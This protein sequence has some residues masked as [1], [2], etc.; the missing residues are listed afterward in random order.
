MSP[1]HRRT[2]TWLL[3][4]AAVLLV[5]AALLPVWPIPQPV[6]YDE[7][8]YLL[9]ADT[10]AH[11]RLTN[12]PHPLWQFFESIYILQQPTYASKY[13]PG[14]GL[15]MAAGQRLAGNAW[16]GVWLSCGALAAALCWALQGWLPLRWA[17]LGSVIS[18][19]L[20][21]FSYWMNSYWGGAVAGIGGAMVVGA[22]A[23]IVRGGQ[24]RQ[25]WIFGIGIVLLLLTRPFE[26]FL[27]A[28]PASMALWA[29]L[30]RSQWQVWLPVASLLAM[31]LAWQGFYDFRVT[32]R[33]WRMPYQEYF[34]QYESVPPLT[35]LPVQPNKVFRH[36]DLEFHDSGWT[37]KVNREARSW[38]LPAIRGKDLYTTLKTI[39]GSS[40]WVLVFAA[41][42]PALLLSRRLRLPVILA[43][44][45]AGGSAIELVYYSHYAAPFAAVL[46]ILLVEGLRRL[47]LLARRKTAGGRKFG[48]FAVAT[49]CGGI[50]VLTWTEHATDIYRHRTPEEIRSVI[51]TRGPIEHDL[52]ERRP[53]KHVIFVR[54]TGTEIPHQ[55]WVYN[56]S[57]I[58]GSDVIWAQDMGSQNG[59]LM[60]YYPARSF[61]LFEPDRDSRHLAPYPQP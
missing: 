9:Q 5:R 53:G 13:P 49:L 35:I 34:A 40:T 54:Y 6:I 15:A 61:W 14:Q 2:S 50:L 19:D 56:A 8:S 22:W 28:A 41:I 10:F 18:L 36:F 32:G 38:R 23:R 60:S 31:G 16:Y 47:N 33:F 46:L 55:E 3:M 17:L 44:L 57:D 29:R 30:G 7:F 48:K 1:A 20:C 12:P 37:R 11:G 26:G 4:G 27:L 42:F 52:L 21:L 58:D 45:M 24:R 43:G 25:A 39:F 51:A 59:R